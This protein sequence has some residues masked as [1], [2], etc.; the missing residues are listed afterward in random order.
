MSKITQQTISIY[1]VYPSSKPTFSK[2]PSLTLL[3]VYHLLNTAQ[4]LDALLNALHVL[5]NILMTQGATTLVKSVLH[6][7]TVEA[8]GSKVMKQISHLLSYSPGTEP[9]FYN[10]LLIFF[11]FKCISL[12]FFL[13]GHWSRGGGWYPIEYSVVAALHWNLSFLSS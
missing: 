8:E 6:M 13:Y 4:E 2:K 3:K 5:C 9:S 1:P 7:K 11:F 12:I 10:F